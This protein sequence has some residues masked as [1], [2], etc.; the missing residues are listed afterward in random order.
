MSDKPKMPVASLTN[1]LLLITVSFLFVFSCLNKLY[2]VLRMTAFSQ[3]SFVN[4]MPNS[5]DLVSLTSFRLS[6]ND[7]FANDRFS[8]AGVGEGRVIGH[9]DV[10]FWPNADLRERLHSRALT[11][12]IC[13]YSGP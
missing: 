11:A 5:T 2:L 10:R 6:L 1:V 12:R 7:E 8:K 9:V 4:W 13:G 3:R